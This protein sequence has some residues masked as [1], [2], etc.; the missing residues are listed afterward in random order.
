MTRITIIIS[1]DAE[2]IKWSGE[3]MICGAEVKRRS[4]WRTL[5][6]NTFEGSAHTLKEK[7]S[8]RVLQWFTGKLKDLY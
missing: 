7:G 4:I 6:P 8:S 1:S 3:V 5:C 2:V